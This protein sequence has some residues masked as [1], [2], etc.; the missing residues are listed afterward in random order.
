[1]IRDLFVLGLTFVAAIWTGRTA[2]AQIV[3]PRPVAQRQVQPT[4][5]QQVPVRQQQRGQAIRS[6]ASAQPVVPQTGGA[7]APKWIPLPPEH[8]QRLDQTLRFWESSTS[9][10]QRYRCRFRCW[11][12]ETHLQTKHKKKNAAWGQG[13]VPPVLGHMGP[14]WVL[15]PLHE[16]PKAVYALYEALVW[17]PETD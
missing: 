3:A 17:K 13:G 6:Q 15:C 9:G 4:Q 1:M 14:M 12:Y 10:I 16:W 11:E 5:R 8:A 2:S 7:L